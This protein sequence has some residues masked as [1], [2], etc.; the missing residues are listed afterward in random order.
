LTGVVDSAVLPQYKTVPELKPVPL[1]VKVNEGLPA[2]VDDGD[3]LVSVSPLVITKG[4]VGGEGTP[5]LTTPTLTVPA[6]AIRLAGTVA[7]S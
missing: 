1:A 7:L 3:R 2:A 6:V 4:N 5:G